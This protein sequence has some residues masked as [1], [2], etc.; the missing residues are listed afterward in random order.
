MVRMTSLLLLLILAGCGRQAEVAVPEWVVEPLDAP[1]GEGSGESHLAVS[2]DGLVILS[3]LEPEGSGHAL[4]FSTLSGSGWAAAQTV[5]RGAA[6]FVNWADFPSVVPIADRLWAAHWLARRPEGGYAYDVAMSLSSDAGASWGATLSPHTDGTPTEH[7]FVTLFPWQGGVGAVWLDGRN[8]QPGEAGDDHSGHDHGAGGMT[9][10]AAVIDASGA[11]SHEFV[12]DELT[13]DC[14]QTDVAVTA[15]G[16]IVAYRDRS[17]DEIR[18]IFVARG[19]ADGW[20]TPIAVANDGW[21]IEGCPVNGPAIAAQEG[22]VVV[23]WFTA[24]GDAPRVRMARSI[25]GGHSFA[26]PVDLDIE[27]PLGRV[28]IVLLSDGDA[29]VS[30]LA[31]AGEGA[32][33]ALRRV[34]RDG[35]LGPVRIVAHTAASRPAGFPQLVVSGEQLVLSWTEVVA[36]SKRVKTVRVPLGGVPG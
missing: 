12:V 27:A 13:C 34:R 6:W 25:D 9:L 19:A 33:V 28:G 22:H 23:A 15:A 17:A 24:A 36:E 3:W 7:G 30:W 20:S 16:P 5:A 29:V 14:C 26:P 31:A 35:G 8:M 10:R 1:A 21:R 2:P 11:L 18:D 32:A 4:R